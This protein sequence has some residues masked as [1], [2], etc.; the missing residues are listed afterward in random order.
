MSE[1]R[2]Q[3]EVVRYIGYKY[4]KALYCASAGGIYTTPRQAFKMKRTGYKKGFPDLFIYEARN[5]YFGLALEI[6]TDKGRA[7]S[8]QKQWIKALTDRGYKAVVA[9]GFDNIIKEIDEY[10]IGKQTMGIKKNWLNIY[11]HEQS[12]R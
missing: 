7:T 3:A 1:E 6:K 8:H 4:P 9:K 12:K 10:F 2:L 5:S 11:K